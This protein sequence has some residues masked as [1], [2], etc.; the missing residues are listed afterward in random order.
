MKPN[1]D[2]YKRICDKIIPDL[3]SDMKVLEIACGTG[4]LSFPLAPFVRHYEATD[5]SPAMIHEA[6]KNVVP[7]GLHFSVE[8]A[9]SLSFENE[10]FDAV[11][12]ANA[13]H[14]MPNPNKALSEIY[15]V[16]KKDGLLYAPTFLKGQ[17]LKAKLR[18]RII[19]L[20]GFRT[21]SHWNEKSFQDLMKKHSFTIRKCNVIQSS[22]L[23]LCYLA[24]KK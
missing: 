23:P 20:A 2:L 13:L 10:S 5:F 17:T 22:F 18:I 15:R 6:N 12:I 21:Y 24:A 14:I 11:I 9:T 8:D 19:G 4:Q 16:L 7:L 1:E 3:S